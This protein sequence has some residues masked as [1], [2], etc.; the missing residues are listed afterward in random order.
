MLAPG[1]CGFGALSH[2]VVLVLSEFY[3]R[4]KQRKS[5][6]ILIHT[7][8]PYRSEPA[9]HGFFLGDVTSLS[10]CS[11]SSPGQD[12]LHDKAKLRL[13]STG[14][15]YLLFSAVTFPHQKKRIILALPKVHCLETARPSLTTWPIKISYNFK[16]N[17]FYRIQGTNSKTLNVDYRTTHY[18]VV[19]LRHLRGCYIIF[20]I[21]SY[22]ISWRSFSYVELY[23]SI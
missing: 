7:T 10:E 17:I 13:G 2:S 21:T 20:L 6:I 9:Q 19:Y 22:K 18:S 4:R 16:I 1:F 14:L 15:C 11:Q 8:S 12:N 23:I 3:S 5:F